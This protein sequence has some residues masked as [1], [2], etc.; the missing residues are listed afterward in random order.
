MITNH[1]NIKSILTSLYNKLLE[2]FLF[3]PDSIGPYN[4]DSSFLV[5][6]HGK[7]FIIMLTVGGNL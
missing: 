7:L 4:L 3:I 1:L 5:K 6:V 2:C